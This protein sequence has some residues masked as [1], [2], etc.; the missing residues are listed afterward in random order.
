MAETASGEQRPRARSTASVDVPSNQL[1]PILRAILQH[2]DQITEQ[3]QAILQLLNYHVQNLPEEPKV[4]SL[5]KAGKDIK[6]LS[7]QRTAVAS[8]RAENLLYGGLDGEEVPPVPVRITELKDA[9]SNLSIWR[10]ILNST[11]SQSPKFIREYH[12][13]FR[14]ASVHEAFLGKH[15]WTSRTYQWAFPQ[16][17][18]FLR[19]D[20]KAKRCHAQVFVNDFASMNA[21]PALSTFTEARPRVGILR[22]LDVPAKTSDGL[23]RQIRGVNA[24]DPFGCNLLWQSLDKCACRGSVSPSHNINNDHRLCLRAISVMDLSPRVL[25][26]LLA[27]TP[28]VDLSYMAAF[29]QRY[30]AGSNWGKATPLRY[31]EHMSS[32]TL[33]YHFSFYYVTPKLFEAASRRPDLR[34]QRRSAPFGIGTSLRSKYIHEENLSFLLIGHFRDVSTCIQLAESYF[35][36]DPYHVKAPKEPDSSIFRKVQPNEPPVALFLSWISVAL[37][38]VLWRWQSAIDA[39]QAEIK[40]SRQ[41]MFMDDRNDLMSDDPNFSLSK[42]YF[43]ALQAYKLFD[44]TIHETIAAWKKF[45]EE[46]LPGLRDYRIPD[47][48]WN[49]SITEI[50]VA[51]AELEKKIERIRSRAEEVKDLRKGLISASALFD[52]RTSVRQGENIRLLTYITLLFL[53]LSFATSIFGMQFMGSAKGYLYAFVSVLPAVTVLT[54]LFVFNMQNIILLWERSADAFGH[55]LRGGMMQNHRKVWHTRAAA[56]EQDLAATR[57]PI[58]RLERETAWIYPI[59]MVE[60]VFVAFPVGELARA[61]KF[62]QRPSIEGK[63]TTNEKTEDGVASDDTRSI[64]P[65]MLEKINESLAE[66][67]KRKR[68]ERRNKIGPVLLTLED[69]SKGAPTAVKWIFRGVT[70]V[71]RILLLPL[72]VILVFFEFFLCMM[73]FLLSWPFQKPSA[74]AMQ[75]V[76]SKDRKVTTASSP[77]RRAF[78]LLGLDTVF[79]PRPDIVEEPF[80]RDQQERRRISRVHTQMTLMSERTEKTGEMQVNAVSQPSRSTPQLRHSPESLPSQAENRPNTYLSSMSFEHKDSTRNTMDFIEANSQMSGNNARSPVTR[81]PYASSTALSPLVGTSEPSEPPKNRPPNPPPLQISRKAVE[82]PIISPTV[83]AELSSRPNSETTEG[84]PVPELVA[85]EQSMQRMSARPITQW[86]EGGES[87]RHGGVRGSSNTGQKVGLG[88]QGVSTIRD[89]E[90][91][92]L[93]NMGG[94]PPTPPPKGDAE[95][96]VDASEDAK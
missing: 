90:M 95:S 65:T 5:P 60:S 29:V 21:T 46:S 25:T 32:Y 76:I 82:T 68:Q 77:R 74:D 93:L 54:A 92:D 24:D 55:W 35:K 20:L 53:P 41:I 27:S 6:R 73:Y 62:L 43:W 63:V 2:N 16:L 79:P 12:D 84:S 28:R 48:V 14:P 3:N 70:N 83:E 94:K 86:S 15:E 61:S 9:D 36:Y 45:S 78:F 71:L 8:Q 30:L 31:G 7:S 10:A 87:S 50:N 44:D 19:R 91:V 22:G 67:Q 37:H 51:I 18:E 89:S 57:A 56:L 64:D 17:H 59:Y 96:V 4:P 88:V 72:W 66:E 58:R 11:S 23:R 47:D 81:S 49:R 75:P 1:A 34:Q 85:R 40:S 13:W 33:E 38:H 80:K 42:T 39:V 69:M 52:S 26:C